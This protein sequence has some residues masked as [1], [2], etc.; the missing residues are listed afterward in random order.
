LQSFQQACTATP[1]RCGF[2][3]G[4]KT[5]SRTTCGFLHEVQ[6]DDA[7]P[8]KRIQPAAMPQSFCDCMKRS[9][10]ASVN[11]NHRF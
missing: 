4:S 9:K 7:R 6:L 8:G 2:S 5:K 3:L 10:V 11:R 1:V